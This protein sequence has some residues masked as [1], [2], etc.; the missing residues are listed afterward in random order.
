MTEQEARLAVA[1]H[2]A[3]ALQCHQCGDTDH[4]CDHGRTLRVVAMVTCD[5]VG[6][7]AVDRLYRLAETAPV[8]GCGPKAAVATVYGRMLEA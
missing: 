7:D 6:P 5:Q 3:H 1:D 8:D 2:V 4:E